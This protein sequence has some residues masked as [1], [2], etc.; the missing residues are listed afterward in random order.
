MVQDQLVTRLVL[1][2]AVELGDFEEGY[3]LHTSRQRT[4]LTCTMPLPK[5]LTHVDPTPRPEQE[6]AHQ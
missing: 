2:P 3:A 6:P 4:E 1:L 5:I